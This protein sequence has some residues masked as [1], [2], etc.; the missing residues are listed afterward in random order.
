MR[1][2]SARES[3]DNMAIK[4]GRNTRQ[5]LEDAFR[6]SKVIEGQKKKKKE[7][8]D[9]T[10]KANWQLNN[11]KEKATRKR[12]Q[13]AGVELSNKELGKELNKRMKKSNN[14]KAY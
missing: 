6:D 9:A 5:I 7:A 11:M 13:D 14:P 12:W 10:N 1:R 2:L 4:S 8:Q 3:G